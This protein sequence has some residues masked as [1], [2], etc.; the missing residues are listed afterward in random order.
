MYG[1]DRLAEI[2]TGHRHSTAVEIAESIFADVA[3]FQAGQPRF[4][5]ET[6]LVLR[7]R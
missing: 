5:D 6:I 4:D 2:L 1:T 3:R 7:V